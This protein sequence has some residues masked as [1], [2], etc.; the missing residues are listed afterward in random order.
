MRVVRWSLVALLALFLVLL[1]VTLLDQGVTF[2]LVCEDSGILAAG[3]PLVLDGE[4]IGRVIM[5]I[6][7]GEGPD[8]VIVRVATRHRF[9]AHRGLRFRLAEAPGEGRLYV[10]VRDTGEG[11]EEPL[12]KGEALPL[13][14][15]TGWPLSDAGP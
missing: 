5:V 7:R 13:E 3:D 15:L 6:P 10:A 1:L 2:T 14:P 4:E 11:S 8:E 12:L 9:K